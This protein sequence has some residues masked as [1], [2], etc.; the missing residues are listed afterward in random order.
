M[1]LT[2][3]RTIAVAALAVAIMSAQAMAVTFGEITSF[4]GWDGS[5]SPAPGWT[6]SNWP[7]SSTTAHNL[8][9]TH[10]SEYMAHPGGWSGSTIKF[11]AAAAGA[12]LSQGFEFDFYM[13]SDGGHVGLYFPISDVNGGNVVE[14]IMGSDSGVIEGA[15]GKQVSIEYAN[16]N[17]FVWRHVEVRPDYDANTVNLIVDGV[18]GTPQPARVDIAGFTGWTNNIYGGNN[19]GLDNMTWGVIPEPATV[20]LLGLGGL[21]LIRRRTR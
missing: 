21:M 6:N 19:V 2:S 8:G 14:V 17:Q 4:E 15:N 20:A 7:A 16:P 1:F 11:T 5:G 13:G 12:D 10:G 3:K 18:A 9:P